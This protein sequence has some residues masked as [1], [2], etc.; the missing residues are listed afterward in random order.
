M[1][2]EVLCH[3][4]VKISSDLNFYFDP[5]GIEKSLFDAD[6]IFV[7]HPHFDHFSIKDINKVIKDETVV[8]APVSMENEL[9]KNSIKHYFLVEP[10]KS[11]EIKGIKV[12]AIPAYNIDKPM[13]KKEYGW[14]GYAIEVEGKKVYVPGDIDSIKEGKSLKVD[15]AFVPVGGTYTLNYSEAADFINEMKPKHVIPYHYGSIVGNKNDGES[16]KNLVDKDIDVII[17]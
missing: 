15:Y 4:S 12:E 3:S 7:T 13:H 8:V 5:F 2:I 16:F 11:Y 1:K 14:V 17:K 6:I 9:K 10:N